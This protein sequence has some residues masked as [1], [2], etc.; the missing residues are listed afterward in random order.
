[1]GFPASRCQVS[2][3]ARNA[4]LAS[5]S[6]RWR[7]PIHLCER[8]DE[9]SRQGRGEISGEYKRQIGLVLRMAIHA[10]DTDF[11]ALAVEVERGA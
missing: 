10:F 7:A 3:S 1:V 2:Y 11:E 5:S 9:W 4:A 8:W 6:E